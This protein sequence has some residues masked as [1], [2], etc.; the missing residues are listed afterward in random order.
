LGLLYTNE[1]SRIGL[2][3]PSFPEILV[4]SKI[5]FDPISYLQNGLYNECT[6]AGILPVEVTVSLLSFLK[7]PSVSEKAVDV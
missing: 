1:E 4:R 3:S 5:H 7:P 2:E 6:L